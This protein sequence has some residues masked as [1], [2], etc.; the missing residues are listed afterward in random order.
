M[1]CMI[2]GFR[3][4]P[5]DKIMIIWAITVI[6]ETQTLCINMFLPDLIDFAYLAVIKHKSLGKK[7][8]GHSKI[9]DFYIPAARAPL[10]HSH[11]LKQNRPTIGKG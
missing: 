5:E 9:R 10:L 6:T 8:S 7:N 4:V 2:Y 1:L 11:H 3:K